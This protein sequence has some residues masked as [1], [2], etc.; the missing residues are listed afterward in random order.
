MIE[1]KKSIRWWPGIV[2]AILGVIVFAAMRMLDVWPYEQAR[3]MGLLATTAATVLLLVVWW[4][5]FSRV[6]WRLRLLPL[7]VCAL[8]PVLFRHRGMTGDFI[9]LFEFR[10]AK[11]S[12]TA[13][14]GGTSAMAKRTDFPQQ[15]GPTRDGRL[16]GPALD[17]DWKNHPPQ[18]L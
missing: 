8:F 11:S 7:A 4:L 14:V 16:D 12:V 3:T 10:F 17:P 13:A 5:F 6:P 15:F 18:V 2:I 1:E 9:P